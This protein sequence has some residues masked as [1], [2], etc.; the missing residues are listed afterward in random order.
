MNFSRGS[1]MKGIGKM[2]FYLYRLIVLTLGLCF[3]A[4]S[5]YGEIDLARFEEEFDII[6]YEQS[7]RA[8]DFSTTDLDKN[9]YRTIEKNL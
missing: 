2:E 9:S 8:P 5:A 7:M 1:L 6:R 4:V 3:F